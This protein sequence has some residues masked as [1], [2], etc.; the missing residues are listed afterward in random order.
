[1]VSSSQEYFSPYIFIKCLLYHSIVFFFV[2][3]QLDRNHWRYWFGVVCAYLCAVFY[4]GSRI[5]QIMLNVSALCTRQLGG[6]FCLVFYQFSLR[7]KP[8]TDSL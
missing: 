2:I 7:G 8:L 3:L 1:M 5:P 4:V 6:Y